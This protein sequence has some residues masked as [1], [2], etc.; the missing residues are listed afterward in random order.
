MAVWPCL[1]EAEPIKIAVF[2]PPLSRDGSGLLY[3][4]IQKDDRQVLAVA[5]VIAHNK[6]DVIA[7]TDFDYDADGL[8]VAAFQ[9]KLFEVG[10]PLP[11]AFAPQPNSGRPS[12]LDID[13]DGRM[14]EPEDAIGYGRFWGDG[15]VVVLSRWPIDPERSFADTT[16]FW[17]DVPGA[18]LPEISHAEDLAKLPVSTSVHMGAWIDAPNVPFFLLSGASTAPVFDGPE[19][20]NG[21]RNAAELALWR[22]KIT[23]LTAPF[24]LAFNANLDPADG[25]GHRD[26]LRDFL[27]D[28]LIIATEPRSVGGV[29]EADPTHIGDAALDTVDW[30]G[31]TP[32]NLRVS[33]V[34]PSVG[35]KVAATGVFWP[36]LGDPNRKLLGEDGLAAGSHRL[37]WAEL[38]LS[39]N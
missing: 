11:Y 27:A 6:P 15:G 28:P 19:D 8:A 21:Y 9:A 3:R 39:K 13:Q 36:D 33:Y 5:A 4:D 1:L 24:V 14:A 18:T 12:G 23:E 32:G 25:E 30:K 16:T 29:A 10:H 37:V 7:L 38:E 2:H 20:L 34:L 31:P 22:S 17:S 35:W 26:E